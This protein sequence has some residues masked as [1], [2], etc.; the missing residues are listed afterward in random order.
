MDRS[1]T[2]LLVVLSVLV[3]FVGGLLYWQ[4][5]A[6]EAEAD[7]EA[8]AEIWQLEREQIT[9][10][11]LSRS[12]GDVHLQ[13]EGGAWFV[14][15]PYRAQ[16]DE[17]QLREL[18][19][20]I[21]SLRRGI[22]VEGA[23]SHPADFGLGEPPDVRVTVKAGDR[24]LT[25]SVGA[26]APT[27]FRTYVRTAT[28]IIAAVN[29]DPGRIMQTDAGRFRD[30]RI[31][32]FDAAEV[33]T[34]S[35][36]S[37]EGTL[38]ARGKEKDWFL[39]GFGRADANKIDELVVGLLD[40]RFDSSLTD[41]LVIE[42]PI[43]RVRVELSDG[44]SLELTTGEPSPADASIAAVT[45]DGRAGSLS[46]DAVAQLKRGPTDLAQ[47]TAFALRLEVADSVEIN[48]GSLH[49]EAH[50]NGPAWQADGRDE[51]DIYSALR[52]LAAVPI[53]YRRDPPPSPSPVEATVVVKE[54][55]RVITVAIG[56]VGAD[57]FRSASDA[58]GGGPFR[59]PTDAFDAVISALSR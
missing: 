38:T 42:S 12:S 41:G 50:R 32:R 3:L 35:I 11:R 14:Q 10:I 37:A 29:G 20:A 9:D 58:G 22:P 2:R 54:G 59:I 17:D 49:L 36:I 15:E 13:N 23:D 44:N 18:L 40:M 55:D 51:G 27:G 6:G 24:D 16:A 47:G 26:T 48:A 57:G 1:Q 56:P 8:I 4:G 31:F 43:Y 33:R 5:E 39:D 21:V 19:D 28:G 45:S 25:I 52:D 34:V 7:P 30:R 53:E 46:P